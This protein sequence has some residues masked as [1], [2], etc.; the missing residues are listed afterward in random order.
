[1]SIDEAGDVVPKL[2]FPP[3]ENFPCFADCQL[4]CDHVSAGDCVTA[5]AL[6]LLSFLV[7]GPALTRGNMRQRPLA[8]E[9]DCYYR[10]EFC[11]LFYLLRLK[12]YK[13]LREQ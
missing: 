9:F 2:P 11:I 6:C 8:A 4:G 13:Y 5:S 3:A 1:M 12:Q 7:R 10:L